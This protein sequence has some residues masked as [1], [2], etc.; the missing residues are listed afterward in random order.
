M[1]RI[2][3]TSSLAAYVTYAYILHCFVTFLSG[4]LLGAVMDILWQGG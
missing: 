4:T 1:L 3:I 2:A